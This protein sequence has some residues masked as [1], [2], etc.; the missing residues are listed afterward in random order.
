MNSLPELIP[1]VDYLL[2]ME[3][4]EARWRCSIDGEGNSECPQFTLIFFFG[5][6]A[7]RAVGAGSGSRP[8]Y[9]RA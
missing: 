5:L 7:R 9:S 2:S 4:E 6:K 8:L 1:D 3:I